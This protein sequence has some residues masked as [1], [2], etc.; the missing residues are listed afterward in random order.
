MPK[1]RTK[2]GK[3]VLS[4]SITDNERNLL[5]RHCGPK[6]IGAFFGRLLRAYDTQVQLGDNTITNRMDRLEN[7]LL[8]ALEKGK[9][10]E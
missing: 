8:E 1:T 7:Y 9:Y 6:E 10:Y 3:Q 4:I 2:S 5:E